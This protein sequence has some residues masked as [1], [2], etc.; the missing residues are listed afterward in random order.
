[1]AE[2]LPQRAGA[3]GGRYSFAA[4]EPRFMPSLTAYL[5]MVFREGSMVDR[6]DRVAAVGYEGIDVFGVD[7]DLASIAR[8]VRERDLTWAYLSGE[9][10]PLTDPTTR[11]EAVEHLSRR[12]ELAERY[13]IR[14]VN[15][16]SGPQQKDLAPTAQ[17]EAVVDGL[18]AV[19]HR[20]E[21]TGVTLVLEPVN[22]K[23]DHPGHFTATAA[24]GAGLVRA[25]DHPSLRL[26][27]DVYHEQIMQGDVIRS[28]R[29]HVDLIGHVHIADNP[30]RH[31][32]GTGELNYAN[33]L[34]AIDES[35][36]A[37]FVGCEFDIVGDRRAE[38]VLRAVATLQ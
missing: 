12:V 1:M 16:K 20:A 34:R 13:D 8:R 11:D 33:V 26:L 14:T 3:P 29:E 2:L 27:F 17:R 5:N 6:V 9:Q 18:Q 35:G 21:G 22:T 30:G 23:I 25:V 4:G 7:R 24:A 38:D 36:Y 37:G 19:A 10:P 15:V 32:P 31:Q 28:F